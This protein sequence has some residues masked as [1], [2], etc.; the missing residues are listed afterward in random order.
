[1]VVY[2]DYKKQHWIPQSYLEEW[3]DPNTPKAYDKYVWRFKSDGSDPKKKAPKNIFFE[4]DMYTIQLKDG[5]RILDIEHGLAGL[6]NTF[7]N[8]RT[9]CLAKHK[10]INHED[11]IMILAFIAAS[12]SR[13][14]SRREHYKKQW[15]SALDLMN[16]MKKDMEGASPERR[17][18]MESLGPL[19]EDSPKFSMEEVSRIA[20]DPLQETLIPSINALTAAFMPMNLSIL[21]TNNNVGF[22]TSDAPCVWFDPKAYER[23]AMYRSPGLAYPRIEITLPI[24]PKQKALLSWAPLND[25]INISDDMLDNSNRTTR[26]Y[27]HEYFIVNRNYTKEIWFDPGKPPDGYKE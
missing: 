19:S 17:K 13:T 1:M 24:S 11:R 25:Y 27:A 23:P 18:A 12:Y 16:F 6:E 20:K 2:M 26:F 7:A 4:P 15:G 9:N 5:T 3:C 14:P 10:E 21:C 22:I 8:I